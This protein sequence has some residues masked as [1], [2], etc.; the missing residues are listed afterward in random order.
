MSGGRLLIG[1]DGLFEYAARAA[2]LTAA[3]S[4]DLSTA[5]DDRVAAARL[6]TGALQDDL[7]FVLAVRAR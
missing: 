6:P 5:A 7:A 3:T 1:T 4:P 2:I